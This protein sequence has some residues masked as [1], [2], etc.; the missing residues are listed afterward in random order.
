MLSKTR[1]ANRQL[2]QDKRAARRLKKSK[3]LENNFNQEDPTPR[4]K[5]TENL[6][7]NP[8]TE[9]QAIYDDAMAEAKIVFGLGP[10]GTGKTWFATMRACQKLDKGQISKIVITR[11]AEA[12]DEDLGYLPGELN[13]KFEP[14][15]RPVKDALIEFFGEAHLEYLLRKK[16]IEPIPLGFLR[17]ATL[18]E[19]VVIADE[20]Q[21]ATKGQMKMLLTRFGQ[22]AQFIINGD[23]KQ[24]DID[25]QSSGLMDAIHRT[26][27]ISAIQHVWFTREDI[28]RE[29]LVQEII[30]AYE[31]E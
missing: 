8:L 17:G 30:D 21:N 29:G 5:P 24:I 23:P 1:K 2:R 7:I 31:N 12:V 22:D 25:K 6:Q 9:S 13:E 26:K 20:M 19:C 15:L 27:K 14:Y 11:P 28:V 3:S 10:A 18:K 16:I 4:K